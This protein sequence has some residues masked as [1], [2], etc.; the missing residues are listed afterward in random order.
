MK[1]QTRTLTIHKQCEGITGSRNIFYKV[2]SCKA[3]PNDCFCTFRLGNWQIK[4]L[5]LEASVP[6]PTQIR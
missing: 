4:M 5:C 3:V 6:V 2:L 1:E